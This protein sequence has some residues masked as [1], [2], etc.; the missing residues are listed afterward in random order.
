MSKSEAAIAKSSDEVIRSVKEVFQYPRAREIMTYVMKSKKREG[1]KFYGENFNAIATAMGGSRS[2]TI[3]MLAFLL[4][5]GYVTNSVERKELKGQKRLLSMYKPT[6][7]AD[8]I[9]SFL[10]D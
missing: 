4:K 10:L 7:K 3:E 6:K 2:L 1:Q 8:L 9:E 5:N